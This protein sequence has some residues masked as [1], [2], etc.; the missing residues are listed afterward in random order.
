MNKHKKL[1]ALCIGTE[2]TPTLTVSLVSAF[3]KED[4]AIPS[5]ESKPALVGE[6]IARG[7]PPPPSLHRVLRQAGKHLSSLKW[8]T[9][10]SW[11]GKSKYTF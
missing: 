3:T 7:N 4:R 11:M 10:E 1:S 9:P 5:P 8:A 6:K 2:L